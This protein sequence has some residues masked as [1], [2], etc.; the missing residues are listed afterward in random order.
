MPSRLGR[1]PLAFAGMAHDD[2][3]IR[4][5][6]QATLGTVAV[7]RLPADRPHG[8]HRTLSRTPGHLFQTTLQRRVSLVILPRPVVRDQKITLAAASKRCTLIP[9]LR[10]V[11]DTI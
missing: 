8:R 1:H 5:V 3:D 9:T 11:A 4:R 10:G 7:V 2:A 6:W